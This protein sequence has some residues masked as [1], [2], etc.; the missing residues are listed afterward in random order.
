MENRIMAENKIGKLNVNQTL[1]GTVKEL[2]IPLDKNAKAK[3]MVYHGV[4]NDRELKLA[5]YRE[6][7]K[8]NRNKRA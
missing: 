6:W 2:E 5:L 8:N 7:L 3:L 1:G 4:T